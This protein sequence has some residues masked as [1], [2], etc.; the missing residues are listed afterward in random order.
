LVQ[1]LDLGN[2]PLANAYLKA[3]DLTKP[4]ASFPLVLY[5]CRACSLAQLLDVV[6]PNLLFKNYHFLTSASNPAVAHFEQYANEVIKP[7]ITS[8]RD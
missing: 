5:F 2:T 6:N 4:D 3:D 7:L 8:P 1:V